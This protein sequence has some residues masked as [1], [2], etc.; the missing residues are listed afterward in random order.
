MNNVSTDRPVLVLSVQSRDIGQ[1]SLKINQAKNS[2]VFLLFLEKLFLF[3][4][5]SGLWYNKMVHRWPLNYYATACNISYNRR[6]SLYLALQHQ[7][8]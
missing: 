4:I 1:C 3:C 5:V 7:A 6:D 8:S 2:K